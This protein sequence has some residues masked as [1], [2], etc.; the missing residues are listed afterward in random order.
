MKIILFIK[1]STGIDKFIEGLN[2]W[3]GQQSS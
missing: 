2:E 1:K 3:K